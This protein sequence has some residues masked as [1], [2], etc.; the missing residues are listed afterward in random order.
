M[1]STPRPDVTL[2]LITRLEQGIKTGQSLSAAIETALSAAL[3]CLPSARFARVYRFVNQTAALEAATD[4]TASSTA[5]YTLKTPL[6][7]DADQA[8]W[9]VPL[10]D[11]E[12]VVGMM[13]INTSSNSDETCGWLRLIGYHLARVIAVRKDNLGINEAQSGA[14]SQ[15]DSQNSLLREA[16]VNEISTSFQGVYSVE[17]TLNAAARGLQRTLNA[18][19]VSILLGQPP[20]DPAARDADDT[21]AN[22]SKEG[23]L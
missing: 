16:L 17:A 23:S 10:F 22:S 12:Q 18:R 15:G 21:G 1:M 3:D 20:I 19:R 8:V 2:N 9:V 14:S 7:Y 6:H 11:G 4:D 5:P 13:E